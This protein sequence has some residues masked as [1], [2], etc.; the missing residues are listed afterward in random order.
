M[1]STAG[2]NTSEWQGEVSSWGDDSRGSGENGRA[3]NTVGSRIS[4]DE[5][6]PVIVI[7]LE[8]RVQMAKPLKEQTV[9]PCESVRRLLRVT[10]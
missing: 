9:G 7:E 1:R 6:Q 5:L 2:P 10:E 4:D 8:E 3:G